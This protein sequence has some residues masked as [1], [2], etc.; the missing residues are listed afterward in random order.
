MS[1]FRVFASTDSGAP[2]L[3][4]QSG[5]LT[6][7]LDAVLVDGYGSG[8]SA[9]VAAGWTREFSGTNK[10]AYRNDPVSGTGYRLR[11][12]D[13]T[14]LGNARYAL[15]RA[16]DTM[17]DVDTGGNAVPTTTQR[18]DGSL[19][20]KSNVLS[21]A[22]RPWVIV[23]NEK[24]AYCFF[25]V[26]ARGIG[27]SCIFW[28]GELQSNKPGDSHAFFVNVTTLTAYT[29]SISD[30]LSQFDGG[31]I[32]SAIGSFGEGVATGVLA[33]SHSGAAG[34]VFASPTRSDMINGSR[35]GSGGFTY[36]DPVS[37]GLLHAPVHVREAAAYTVRG[38]APGLVCPQHARPLSDG[39]TTTIITDNGPVTV[40]VKS[41]RTLYQSNSSYN[42]Q[43]LIDLTTDY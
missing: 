16:Y 17:S 11:V 8:P 31:L 41:F 33:R 25:D 12:D 30:A 27:D 39:S 24:T 23:A 38:R 3:S 32:G 19:W 22:A 2:V 4:G 20:P 34:A 9:K 37:G 26:E 36:P 29:G 14:T 21:S 28:F 18:T 13:S 35:P 40:Y 5:A 42:G 15:V 6:N 1:A 10:R 43:L 7:L